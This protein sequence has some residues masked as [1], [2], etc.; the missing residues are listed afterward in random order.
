M[1][2]VK[3]T[4]GLALSMLFVGANVS[5]AAITYDNS[6]PNNGSIPVTVSVQANEFYDGE[7][8]TLHRVAA[9]PLG[10]Y[11][12]D[13]N[14]PEL[15]SGYSFPA[16]SIQ[17][18]DAT[19]NFPGYWVYGNPQGT[20]LYDYVLNEDRSDAGYR[21]YFV[22]DASGGV[23]SSAGLFYYDV[24]SQTTAYNRLQVQLGYMN[25]NELMPVVKRTITLGKFVYDAKNNRNDLKSE[26]ITITDWLVADSS[27]FRPYMDRKSGIATYIYHDQILPMLDKHIIYSIKYEVSIHDEVGS[28]GENGY[29]P[30][31]YT[32]VT[33]LR[34]VTLKTEDGIFTTP[35]ND[36][37]IIYTPSHEDFTF[38]AYSNTNISVTTD[39][40]RDNE[41]VKVVDNKDGSFGVTIRRVQSNMIVNIKSVSTESGTGEGGTTGNTAPS[42][43]AVWATNGTLYVQTAN[44]ATISVYSVTGQLHKQV[45]VNGSYSQAMSKGIYIVQLNGKAY[46]VVL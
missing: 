31:V 35:R 20:G 37:G 16:S 11:H 24:K 45:A 33:V 4:L 42:D 13:V 26:N 43:D 27:W 34:G 23:G 15:T 22:P 36:S 38:T 6:K 39:R 32:D 41:G 29:Q 28:P 30:P 19:H 3:F 44:P 12:Y 17:D 14:Y 8:V 5:H 1:K 7:G 46:K 2:K 25:G 21:N 9:D 18:N 10:Y 40:G